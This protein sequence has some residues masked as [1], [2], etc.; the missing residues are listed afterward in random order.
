M[1]LYIFAVVLNRIYPVNL[2]ACPGQL[3]A[4]M[5]TTETGAVSWLEEGT[6][7]L[8]ASPSLSNKSGDQFF[9]KLVG[10][11][12]T[13]YISTATDTSISSADNNKDIGCFDGTTLVYQPILVAGMCK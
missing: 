7:Y 11:N 3:V 5:C 4:F 12:G 8:F 13:T 6:Y 2:P 9:F 1:S 10:V